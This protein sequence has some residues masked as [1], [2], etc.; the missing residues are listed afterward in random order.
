MVN[1]DG[2]DLVLTGLKGIPELWR[3][4]VAKIN[5]HHVS[6][7]NW[8]ANIR[9]VD[10]NNQFP[11]SWEKIKPL[12]GVTKPSP[13]DFPGDSPLTEPEAVALVDL[14]QQHPFQRTY[15]L[16]TQGR[17]IYW[18]F[19]GFEPTESKTIAENLSLVSEYRSV[20]NIESY[21]GYR[22]WF[23]QEYRKPGF[24]IELGYGVNPLPMDHYETVKRDLF[25][26]WLTMV[27]F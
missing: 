17:E 2:F 22:D 1:P 6:F 9:G 10:L 4:R 3:D 18:G 5:D 25:R 24:T 12:K 7:T 23:L 27:I 15:S 21:G 14:S 19:Q 11:A 26:M 20:Q 13:R 16:H 8:K